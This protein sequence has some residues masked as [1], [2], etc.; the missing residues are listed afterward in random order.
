MLQLQ[1]ART[2]QQTAA[3]MGIRSSTSPQNFPFG[4]GPPG[5]ISLPQQQQQTGAHISPPQMSDSGG[6]PAV[7]SVLNKWFSDEVLR[8]QQQQGQ[9]GLNG[10]ESTALTLEELEKLHRSQKTPN[11]SSTTGET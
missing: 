5:G 6:G 1:A 2:N 3:A 8:H 7:S 4:M 11:V 10:Q 9:T